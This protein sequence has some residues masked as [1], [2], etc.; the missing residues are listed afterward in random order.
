MEGTKKKI[1]FVLN[2]MNIGGVE[3]SLLGLLDSLPRDKYDVDLG[4]VDRAGGFLDY[5]PEGV[6]I[7]VIEPLHR[8][9]DILRRRL[10]ALPSLL[11]KGKIA[12]AVKLLG[13]YGLSQLKGTLNPFYNAFIPDA[14]LPEYDVAVSYQGPS[15]LLDFFVAEKVKARKKIAWIHFDIS[16]FFVRS[17]SVEQ[18][19]PAFDCICVVSNEAAGV[20]SKTFPGLAQKVR[21]FPNIVNHRLHLSLSAE[22]HPDMWASKALKILTV[23]RLEASKG[24]DRA[25]EG[26]GALHER[27]IDFKWIFIGAGSL[28]ESLE[29]RATELGLMEKVMFTG[30]IANPYPYMAEA[31][32]YVQPSRHEG[33]GLTIAE[34]MS[35]GLP[36]VSSDTIGARGQL[37]NIG[38][39][40]IIKDFTP[41]AVADAILDARNFPHTPHVTASRP[42][43]RL[44]EEI[45]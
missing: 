40:V 17:K 11:K 37:E 16:H 26:A 19:Y 25:L 18:C 43:S 38:S 45:F 21:V 35:F 41:D 1:L 24:P 30:A 33:F 29:H 4:L 42:D 44:L 2:D 8:N 23:G 32:V 34:A 9:A 7:R 3:K 28:K 14:N 15:E 6:N 12:S 36:V 22:S 31:D 20:F 13:Y 10:K 27:G 39:A 5:V